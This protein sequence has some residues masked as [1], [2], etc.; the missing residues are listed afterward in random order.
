MGIFILAIFF[1]L[2]GEQNLMFFDLDK[3]RLLA[4]YD[5][6]AESLGRLIQVG[7]FY[8][9][10]WGLIACA[11]T[12]GVLIFE[13]VWYYLIPFVARA[14]IKLI[15]ALDYEGKDLNVVIKRGKV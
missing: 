2:A 11:Y 15:A 13:G 12:A 7:V 1:I 9:Q 3:N 4:S 8:I 6:E 14:G 10:P 5:F